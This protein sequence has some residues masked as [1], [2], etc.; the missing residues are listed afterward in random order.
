MRGLRNRRRHLDIY[1]IRVR[2]SPLPNALGVSAG[3]VIASLPAYPIA[4]IAM[5]SCAF[6][7]EQI[8]VQIRRGRELNKGIKE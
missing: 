6:Q 8:Q 4:I 7:R 3:L 5:L 1:L 2:F